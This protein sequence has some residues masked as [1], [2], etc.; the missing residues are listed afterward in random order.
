MELVCEPFIDISW[1]FHTARVLIHY[2]L[3]EQL[4]EKGM[5]SPHLGYS[6]PFSA[7]NQ[8]EVRENIAAIIPPGNITSQMNQALA[9]H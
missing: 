1:M 4:L 2:H 8:V 7:M 3:E 6:M 5:V 9:L